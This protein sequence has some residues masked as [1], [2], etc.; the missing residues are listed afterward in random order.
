MDIKAFLG[1]RVLLRN[2]DL[3]LHALHN[4]IL[5]FLNLNKSYIYSSKRLC[6]PLKWHQNSVSEVKFL[7]I[8]T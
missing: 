4:A 6:F 1:F 3:W 7:M 8:K 2:T 5:T